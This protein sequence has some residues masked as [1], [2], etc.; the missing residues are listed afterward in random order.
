VHVVAAI[1]RLA[2]VI[3]IK[4]STLNLRD[5]EAHIR[6]SRD[7]GKS[8]FSG[9][10]LNLTQFM[11]LGGHGAM[12]PEAALLP[13][14]TVAVYEAWQQGDCRHARRLQGDL[15]QLAPILSSCRTSPA[16]ARC[17]LM[18][19]QDMKIPVPMT[20]D[21]SPVKLKYALN[22]LGVAT[23]ITVRPPQQPL[24]RCDERQIEHAVGRMPQRALIVE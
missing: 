7:L 23:P 18:T 24:R 22:L 14:S 13:G 9:T 19:L 11:E 5:V 4:E 2:N 17:T 3:G 21:P 1:L 8:Y 20:G 12:C 15:F 10:A 6:L 16:L